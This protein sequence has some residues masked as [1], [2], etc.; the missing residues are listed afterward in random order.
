[1][2]FTYMVPH[3]PTRNLFCK[4]KCIH[5]PTNYKQHA[6]R[7]SL[8]CDGDRGVEGAND[9]KTKRIF[10]FEWVAPAAMPTACNGVTGTVQCIATATM[11]PPV[12]L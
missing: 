2:N 6:A 9:I 4:C 1:M 12:T 7:G 3:Q 11:H 10:H 5:K 8:F